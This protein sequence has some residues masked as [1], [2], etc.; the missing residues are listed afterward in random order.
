MS[1]GLQVTNNGRL[2]Q[3]LAIALVTK[4][5]LLPGSIVVIRTDFPRAVTI[6]ERVDI[7]LRDGTKLGARIWLPVDADVRPVPAIVEYLPYRKRDETH[8]RDALPY[9]NLAGNG[10]AGVRVDIR[11]SGDSEGLLK[12]RYT[13][14]EHDDALEVIAWVADQPWCPGRV[15]MM[16]I[17]WGSFNEL[18]VAARRP[19]VP[20]AIVTLCS[21]NDR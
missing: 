10:Y 16:G 13:K 18:Q 7:P 2:A 11:G 12:D 1:R 17:S 9:L 4:P 6:L 20:K 3:A 19:P 21:T 15:G 8:E 14:Q 5:M